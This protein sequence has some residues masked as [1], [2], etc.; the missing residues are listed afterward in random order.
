MSNEALK[1]EKKITLHNKGA[2]IIQYNG[3]ELKPNEHAQ[4]EESEVTRLL[5]IF[6]DELCKFSDLAAA[7]KETKAAT[8]EVK[9]LKLKLDTVQDLADSQAGIIADLEKEVAK[10][11]EELKLFAKPPKPDTTPAK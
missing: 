7:D 6:P 5:K 4:V 10:L 2:R 1:E 3:G 8:A 11:T 9:K